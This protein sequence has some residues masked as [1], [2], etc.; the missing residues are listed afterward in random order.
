M[1]TTHGQITRKYVWW[2]ASL[3]PF[4]IEVRSWTPEGISIKHLE[5]SGRSTSQ[6][7]CPQPTGESGENAFHDCTLEGRVFA[8]RASCFTLGVLCGKS[9][10]R[11][12]APCLVYALYITQTPNENRKCP[13]QGSEVRSESPD[14]WLWS[15]LQRR[16]KSHHIPITHLWL[17]CM[18]QNRVK[19]LHCSPYLLLKDNQKPLST[20]KTRIMFCTAIWQT[21]HLWNTMCPRKKQK[22][23]K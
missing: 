12:Y 8:G 4:I 18:E 16:Q 20:Q 17:R 21:F 1:C 11:G 19:E 13:E 9:E 22:S 14:I 15:S 5:F 23:I 10:K 2:T 7:A 6:S 3:F